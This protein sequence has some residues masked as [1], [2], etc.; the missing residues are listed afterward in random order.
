M[1]L[2]TRE[3][4]EQRRKD[5]TGRVY[6]VLKE[7]MGIT[8]RDLSF[9]VDSLEPTSFIMRVEEEFGITIPDED[10]ARIVEGGLIQIVGS[11]G[12]GHLGVVDYLL[13]RE[14]AK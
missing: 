14:D 2:H 11:S 6:R 1:S 10:A 12:E 7:G 3:L 4:A 13:S 5:Y 9:E 8:P